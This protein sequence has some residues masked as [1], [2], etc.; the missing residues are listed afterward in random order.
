[1]KFSFKKIGSVLASTAMLSSTVALAAAANFPE[2]FV[3][4]AGADVAIVHGGVNAAYTDLVAVADITS[5][6]ASE[7][8]SKTAKGGTSTKDTVVGEAAQLFTSG[9]KL[10][11][12]DT[13]NQIKSVLTETQLPIV[14]K[15]TSF[16]GN[17][18]ANVDHSIIIGS[19][20]QPIYAK[21]PT[22]SFDPDI[23][24]QYSSTQANYLYNA[25]ATFSKTINFSHADSK[26]EDLNLFGQKFT[27]SSATTSS[28][29]VLLKSAERVSLTNEDP[30]KEVVIEG[31]TYTVELVSTSDTSATVKVTNSAGVSTSKEISE[32]ASKKVGDI[33]IAVIN[34]D[35][36]NL[37]LSA[38][39][40]VGAEKVTLTNA[41]QVKVGDDNTVVDG[42][43]VTFPSG[44]T[45][46]MTKIEISVYAPTS[47]KDFLRP[48]ESF[49]DP[50]F[51]TFKVDFPSIS[52]PVDS[53]AREDIK[54]AHSGDDKM[55]VTFSDHR[56][57][58]STA[59]QWARNAT[60]SLSLQKDSDG[61]NISVL[62]NEQTFDEEYIV[63]GNEDHGYLLRV[64]SI[65][66]QSNAATDDKV[67]FIDVISGETYTTQT[68]SA[69]GTATLIL[70]HSYT[71][72]YFGASNAAESAKYIKVNYP[73]STGQNAV[74]YPT[75]QTS[76]GSKL[77]FY[78]P[79][80]INM[81]DWDGAD[82]NLAGLKVPMEMLI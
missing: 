80:T 47:D 48:G 16:S 20:P 6:L 51:G 37:L 53:T 70:D 36:N 4:S 57:K 65:T 40:V 27:I 43:L 45:G 81:S 15:E 22:S 72:S 78:E 26:G 33:T 21:E 19:N 31:K 32:N 74:I 28:D 35:E 46:N 75:I 9:T 2:P 34:S 79:K 29:L 76:K 7:L 55:T 71:V 63:L 62:E 14:L 59:I 58:E 61:R 8:A 13:L 49:V 41:N 64:S 24:L 12:N 39:L 50:V 25:T 73:D 60:A 56:N 38:T 67:S 82:T 17:V 44:Q 30:S 5:H 42:T 1:M 52:M 77:F 54:I 3:T 18:D 68:A 23:G 69:E 11:L 10:Y 66:N